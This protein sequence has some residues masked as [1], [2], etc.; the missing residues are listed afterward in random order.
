MERVID[1]FEKAVKNDVLPQLAQLEETLA[2]VV[3]DVAV[4]QAMYAWWVERRK[5]LA[6][7]LIRT[8]RPPPG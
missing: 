7:P 6:Q 1:T 4:T 3:P 5:Y 8:L 2:P